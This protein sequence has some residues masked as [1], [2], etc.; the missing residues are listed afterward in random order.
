MDGVRAGTSCNT[1]RTRGVQEQGGP[2]NI[3]GIDG[4]LRE[5]G[6][7]SCRIETQGTSKRNKELKEKYETVVVTGGTAGVGRAVVQA[8]ARQ[9]CRIGILA[10]DRGRLE[11]AVKETEKLGGKAVG[12]PT[13]VADAGQVERAAQQVEESFGPIDIWVNN[14]MTSVFAPFTEIRPEEFRRV[15]E[16]TYLGQVY[17]TMAALKRMLPRNHG[18]I[19]QVGSALAYRSIPLQSAY[20]GA[21]HGIKGFTDSVRT[22]LIHSRSNVHITMVQMPALNT[23]QFDWVRSRLKNRAQPVP[24]IYQP[25]VAADAIVWASRHRRREVYVGIPTLIAIYGQKIAPGFAGRYVADHDYKAQQTDEPED[26]NRPDNLFTPVPG[27][28]A[29]HGRFSARA[30]NRSIELWLSKHK[31]ALGGALAAAAAAGAGV[32]LANIFKQEGLIA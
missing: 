5:A 4:K 10:R 12:I 22:E 29:A 16:V 11:N 20:C 30:Y 31:A 21:K 15:T 18:T 9:G 17:G 25:E 24:P 13:D 19:V 32:L 6:A 14:A 26:P 23:P 2:D 27:N 28:Y 3:P 8:F 1:G 7:Q